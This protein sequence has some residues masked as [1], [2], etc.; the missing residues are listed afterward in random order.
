MDTY[1]RL[2]KSSAEREFQQL[3]AWENNR[4]PVANETEY[5]I[6]DIEFADSEQ[7]ARVDMLG[8]RWLSD[9]RQREHSLVPVL[10]E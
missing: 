6:T 10:V 4:S 9:E 1:F 5:F 2:D 7:H 3:V 8:V